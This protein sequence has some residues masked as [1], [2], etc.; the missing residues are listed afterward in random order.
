ML[1]QMAG[2]ILR[3]LIFLSV[4]ATI[5]GVA[6]WVNW[7]TGAVAYYRT[8]YVVAMKAYKPLA[9]NG[10]V[11]AQYLVGTMYE[12]DEGGVPQDY[13]VA[14]KWYLLAAKGGDGDSQ[15]KI[16]ELYRKGLGVP[17]SDVEE[18]KWRDR[19][20]AQGFMMA[21]SRRFYPKC[22]EAPES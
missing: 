7:D 1:K 21:E 6:L 14:A 15:A 16:G 20:A 4:I 3:F 2:I 17:Q 18:K 22:D 10:C 12:T 11:D 13:S 5:G 9:E 8:D 19:S